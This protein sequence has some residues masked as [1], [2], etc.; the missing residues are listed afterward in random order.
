MTLA[1]HPIFV[2]LAVAVA[3]PLLAEVPIGARIP[4]VVIEVVL[5]I[6][7]GPH[8]LGLI[9]DKALAPGEFLSVMF[10][11]GVAATLFMAGMELDFAQIRGRPLS[12][13]FRAWVSSLV[14]ALLL[15][16]TLHVIPGVRAPLMVAI[17]M[18]T[19][20]LGVLLPILRDGGQL[21][22]PLGHHLLAAGTV[23]EVAPIVAAA[24]A[25][26]ERYSTVQ[27]FGLLIALLA[28]V[29]LAVSIGMGVRPPR[30]LALL[31]RTLQTSTQ[32][33]MHLAL[34]VLAG[35]I[36]VATEFGFEAILGA[37]AAGMVVGLATRG[38]DGKAFRAKIDAVCFGWFTPFFFVGTGMQFDIWAL[39]REVK[40]MLLV[41][42]F[43]LLFLLV[44]GLPVLLY[45][46]HIS[47]PDRWPFALSAAVPSLGLVVV[48]TQIGLQAKS[49]NPD[50]AQALVG[51][52]L[53]SLLVYTTLAGVLLAR[54]AAPVA[55]PAR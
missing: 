30:L 22:M 47:G 31:G 27:E 5:G 19:T 54:N 13:A 7:I 32:L 16:A 34:F 46:D 37:F 55:G 42:T 44:R 15:V 36:V 1:D 3:A 24:L 26:S 6:L 18:E 23:G 8:A 45:R 52:A 12:L 40:T 50:I 11:I 9:H 48:I 25:L 28:I 53:L 35:F 38:E 49:M 20:G 33:P 17:A 10:M 21:E 51:A 41:P 2:I 39:T 43:L 14:I 4:V 29:G